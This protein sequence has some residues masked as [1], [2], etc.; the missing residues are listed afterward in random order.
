MDKKILDPY[1]ATK[2]IRQKFAKTFLET[3]PTAAD[4]G[5]STKMILKI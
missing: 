4:A 2:N 1:N 3:V 5:L